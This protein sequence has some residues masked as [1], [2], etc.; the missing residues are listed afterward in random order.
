M[1]ERRYAGF[2]NGAAAL[3]GDYDLAHDLVQDGFARAL[4]ERER[5]RGGSP[6]AWVWRIVERRAFDARRAAGP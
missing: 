2:R 4:A 3:V 6:E 5:F 1:Y